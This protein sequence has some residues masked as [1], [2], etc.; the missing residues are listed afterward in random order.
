MRV[1]IDGYNLALPRGTGVATYGFALARTLQEMGHEVDGIFGLNVGKARKT[2]QILFFDAYRREQPFGKRQKRRYVHW[3]M[4]RTA[5][6][7]SLYDVPLDDAVD[8][9]DLADR[10]PAFSRLF[11]YPYLFELAYARFRLTGRFLDVRVPQAPEVMHWTYP[12]PIR[13]LGARNIYTVHDLVPLRLPHTTGDNKP[14]FHKLVE[15]C[16]LEGDHVCTVS[17]AS[18]SDILQT[19]SVSSERVS[20][21]YQVS[22]V[23]ALVASSSLGEDA[24]AVKELFGLDSGHFFLFFG[25]V[26]PKK[27]VER[28]LNAYLRSNSSLPLVVVLG[29]DWGLSYRRSRKDRAKDTP[30]QQ[31][32]QGDRIIQ[33]DYLP[34]D[35]LFR[36][37]RTARAVAFPSLYEG[38]GLPVL[39]ALQ[40]GTPVITSNTSSLPEVVGAAG[41]QIDPYDIDAL[42]GAF[43]AM[44]R[45]EAMY[46]RL[47]AA[48]PDQVAAFS[49]DNYCKRLAA[50]Y[51]KVS[52][53][54]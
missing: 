21:C 14:T 45:D 51:D 26:D 32:E 29:R 2:R 16:I 34:R 37:I 38:F 5:L 49:T 50:M 8:K 41:L 10:F 35:M 27:N 3:P 4:L 30:L 40:L 36:L 44:E 52:A 7:L 53:A 43:I 31:L 19:F 1:A 47:L 11:S 24:R 33:L 42:A 13:L 18:R 22:P 9:R 25:A 6:P 15:K 54:G 17:E 28:L 48:I 46:D 23:P 39:E 12:V 20:N